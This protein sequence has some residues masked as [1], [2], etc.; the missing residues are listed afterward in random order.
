MSALFRMA[1]G[2]LVFLAGVI[3]AGSLEAA[4]APVLQHAD[5]YTGTEAVAGWLMSEKLD[6]IRGYWTGSELLT[7]KGQV[8][9]APAWF[10]QSLP[11]FAL[12]GELWRK[13][14]D[15]SFV[16]NTV[17]DQKPSEN[18]K[19]ITY[20]IFEVPG[21]S[22]DFPAR[23]DK[24]RKWFKTHRVAHVRIIDQ[25]VCSG[26]DHL[27]AFLTEIESRGGEGVVIKDPALSF[28]A[29]RSPRVLK[30]KR[31]SDMEGK[32]IAINPGEGR[33]KGMMGSLT[34]VLENGTEFKLGTGFTDAERRQPPAIG[35][36]VTF[37]YQGLTKNGI[38]RF[39]SF[40]RVRK[41]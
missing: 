30:V 39:A 18:W 24:A 37:K 12:D 38:P 26:P 8:I 3:P 34:L 14:S 21:A 41:D 7:R 40:M 36:T 35:T 2:I 22:G 1:V 9:H 5:A 20:N 32:V 10:T 23:L 6:G 33:L 31:F 19:E 4:E 16:Q 29:G 17:M 15:F 27:D 28:H 11:P 25:I 13:R